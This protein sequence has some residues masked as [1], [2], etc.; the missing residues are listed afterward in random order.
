MLVRTLSSLAII[1]SA[2]DKNK[3]VI[4]LK[5]LQTVNGS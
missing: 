4:A 3:S 2:L 1:N 5:G